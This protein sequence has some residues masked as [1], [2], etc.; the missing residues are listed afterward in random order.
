MI[1]SKVKPGQFQQPEMEVDSW[2]VVHDKNGSMHE[3]FKGKVKIEV[4]VNTSVSHKEKL[5]QTFVVPGGRNSTCKIPGAEA[6]TGIL[7]VHCAA[8]NQ[9]SNEQDV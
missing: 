6:G 9:L 8:A 1:V 7:T 4:S 5:S 3:L 2:E